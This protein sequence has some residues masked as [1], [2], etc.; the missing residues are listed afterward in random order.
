MRRR[1]NDKPD[2]GGG[3][4]YNIPQYRHKSNDQ[5]A[6]DYLGAGLGA[7]GAATTAAM[8]MSPRRTNEDRLE[9]AEN[10][11]RE[12]NAE[13]KRES[14]GIQKP[15]NFDAM[16]ES[17]RDA[18]DARDRKK[19]SGMG[20]KNGGFVRAADGIAQRGKTRGKMC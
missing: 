14:R 9:A 11:K 17:K 20:Y 13:M 2:S 19:I 16:E 3:G 10:A 7:A 4:G 6:L 12:S 15:A 8:A 1:L 18:Q 5:E